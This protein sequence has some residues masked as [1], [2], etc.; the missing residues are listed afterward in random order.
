[1]VARLSSWL[2]S[3]SRSALHS[4]FNR[5]RHQ[6]SLLETG[7]RRCTIR[8]SLGRLCARRSNHDDHL[9]GAIRQG[10]AGA[11]DTLVHSPTYEYK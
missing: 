2:L 11:R 7:A 5:R 10:M 9:G 3:P 1:M 8:N 4:H 6:Q